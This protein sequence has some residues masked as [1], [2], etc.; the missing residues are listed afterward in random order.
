MEAG[1]H[2][3]SF[4]Q[5]LM[6]TYGIEPF[7]I[8]GTNPHRWEALLQLNVDH[9]DSMIWDLGSDFA[10]RLLSHSGPAALGSLQPERATD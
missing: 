10:G 4:Y 6:W 2:S 3:N 1:P 8:S 5:G 7:Y 9:D